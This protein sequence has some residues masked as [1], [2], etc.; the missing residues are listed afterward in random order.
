MQFETSEGKCVGCWTG[1]SFL[2]ATSLPV[3]KKSPFF[4][5][6]ES[7][8]EGDHRTKFKIKIKPLLADRVVAAPTVDE[9]KASIG[10]ISLSPSPVVSHAD[11]TALSLPALLAICG[12]LLLRLRVWLSLSRLFPELWC[13]FV[14]FLMHTGVAVCVCCPQ[15]AHN[16]LCV[17]YYTYHHSRKQLTAVC[18]TPKQQHLTLI[19]VM[20]LR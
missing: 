18:T 17:C 6:D 11:I 16:I 9:L 10:N 3:T 14:F 1:L 12:F 20:R 2:N 8:E 13:F 7:D 4:S 15:D 19:S 5:S